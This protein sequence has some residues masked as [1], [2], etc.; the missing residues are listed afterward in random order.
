MAGSR[1][2]NSARNVFAA[3][4][5]QAI[6]AISSFVVRAVFVA[7]LAAEFVGLETLFS[8]LLTILALADLG[9]GSAI[10]FA[11]YE[12]LA[13]DD[14][15]TIKSIMRLF[16]RAY[17]TIGVVIIALGAIMTPNVHFLL[18]ADAPDIPNLEI[19]F[20]C[21]VLNTGVSYFF[22]YKGAL[23]TADQKSYIVYIITYAFQIVM[24]CCQ[25]AVLL[26]THDYL[27]FLVC[28]VTST[29]LQ[30]ACIAWKCNKMY[31]FILEKDV[32]PIDREILDTI[33]KNVAG[34]MMHKLAGAA[35]TPASN[36]II[37]T[38]VGL[39][40]TSLYGNYL[41][42]T[43][44]MNRIVMRAFE[45][46]IASVGNLVAEESEERQYE[47]FQTTFFIDTLIYGVIAG[48]MLCAF[49][50]FIVILTGSEDWCFPAY[51]VALIVL[52]FYVTG[53]RQAGQTFIS[54]Y[55]LY[56]QTKWKAVLEAITLP[57]FGVILVQFFGMAGVLAGLIAS[58]VF[59]STA[60]E[61]WAI[62][63]YGLHRKLSPYFL[64]WLL[65]TV[66]NVAAC[67]VAFLI[68][69]FI[70]LQ[71]I[72]AFFVKG[73]VGVALPAIAL[74]AVFGRR[75]EAREALSI[76]KRIFRRVAGRLS[77]S[78]AEEVES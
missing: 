42:V 77:R 57:L 7:S 58:N 69:G 62:F 71:P 35:A 2:F 12:P 65:Y 52:L 20:F 22:S 17:I 45:A 60:Y 47:V 26:L 9:I 5:G 28:M 32:A 14:R 21:F 38:F 64:R 70:G 3:W 53:M 25:I 73:V 15:E 10:V 49:N 27:L 40:T 74:F 4:G 48:G 68:C 78:K 50:S 36:L 72:A 55:G 34:M 66:V 75:R 23:I 63:K 51:M 19:Y 39:M 54:A 37:T 31:P 16:K 43:T 33:K 61:G 11:L 30:N 46:I 1:V 18:G 44:S 67:A 76:V 8:S 6:S 59:V 29:V 56:W 24:A 13:K 41:L